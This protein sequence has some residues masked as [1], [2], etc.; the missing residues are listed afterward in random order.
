MDAI[1]IRLAISSPK[2]RDNLR[3]GE[4][5]IQKGFISMRNDR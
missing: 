1:I 4:V 5:M 2:V 3:C